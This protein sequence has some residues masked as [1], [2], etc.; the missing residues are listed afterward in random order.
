MTRPIGVLGGTFDPIHHGHLRFALEAWERLNLDSVRLI[1]LFQPP[2]RAAPI[3]SPDRR[4]AML[5]AAIAGVPGLMADERELRR[6]AV[7]YTVDTLSGL[8]QDCGPLQ[9]LCLLLGMDAFQG[10]ATWRRWERLI[11]LAHLV[12]AQ[13]PEAGIPHDGLLHA[14]LARHGTEDPGVLHAQPAGAILFCAFTQLDI[15]ASSVRALIAAGKSPRY[16]LPEAVLNVIETE[17]LYR[18]C[19]PN[20]SPAW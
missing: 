14:L 20:S 3:A 16:L 5:R 9:P 8:R 6:H 17:H 10:L 2:H 1:P 18:P 13:R 4:L 12:V 11:D 7:S 19:N 15:S